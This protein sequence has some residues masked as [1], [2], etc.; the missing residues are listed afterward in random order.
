MKKENSSQISKKIRN[1]LIYYTYLELKKKL[2][3]NNYLLINSMT[4][5]ELNNK[6]QKCSDYCVETI[7]TYTSHMNNGIDNSNYFH[8]SVTYCSLNN[9]YHILVDNKNVDQ[10]IGHNNIVGKYYKGNSIQIGTTTDKIKYNI[11]FNENKLEKN[12]I[13]AKKFMV[14]RKGISSSLDITKNLH[15]IDNEKIN[16][17]NEYLD[18]L[19]SNDNSK[20]IKHLIKDNI[21][22]GKA[23]NKIR[24][25]NTQKII[26]KNLL[27]LKKYCANLILIEKKVSLKKFVRNP[28]KTLEPSSPTN[29]KRRNKNE[30]NTL[31]FLKDRPKIEDPPPILNP[32]ENFNNQNNSIINSK[33]SPEKKII[34]IHK[35]IKSQTKI[36]RNIFKLQLKS[37]FKKKNNNSIEKLEEENISPKKPSPTTIISSKFFSSPKKLYSPKKN[38]IIKK[39]KGNNIFEFNSGGITYSKFYKLFQKFNKKEKTNDAVINKFLSGNKVEISSNKR[40]PNILNASSKLNNNKEKIRNNTLR[41]NNENNSN[42]KLKYKKALSINKNSKFMSAGRLEKK[43]NTIQIRDINKH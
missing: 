18:L 26:N 10:Y 37:S 7:E 30:K 25:T 29:K 38:D 39:E 11:R 1:K 5:N 22:N 12:I 15:I 36:F 21:N 35:K 33:F 6:Y 2:M 28:N 20:N 31:K 17:I 40:K 43:N 14:R 13:G 42:Y 32:I 4:P 9:N 24:K 19:K 16:E 34:A 3:E 27:K 23:T 41:I 8:V